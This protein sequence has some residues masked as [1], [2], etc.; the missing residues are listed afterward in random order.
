[1][2]VRGIRGA[3]TVDNDTAPEV[4]GA[5]QALLQTIQQANGFGT[6]DIASVLFTATPDIH[7]VFP[8]KAARLL[9][10]DRVP[11]LCFQEIEVKGAL[12]RCI[13]V[14]IHINTD[15]TQE[16]IEHIYLGGAKALRED[17]LT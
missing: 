17:L 6:D 2:L 10:W 15:K 14:L 4:L 7:S 16:Q 11:L 13:R 9:G 8:A 12:P 3:V 5:T 1:M